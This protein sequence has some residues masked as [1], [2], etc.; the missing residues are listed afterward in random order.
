[1]HPENND[2]VERDTDL[3]KSHAS[4]IGKRKIVIN[5]FKQKSQ[6]CKNNPQSDDCITSTIKYISCFFDK[7][8]KHTED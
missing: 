1:M 4:N 5:K 3:W 8:K 6:S 7:S 2:Q